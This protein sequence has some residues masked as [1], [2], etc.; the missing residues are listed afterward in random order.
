MPIAS[1]AELMVLAVYMP[2]HD[3]APGQASH[4]TPWTPW[5]SSL[6]PCGSVCAPWVWAAR[7][8]DRHD[9]DV[10]PVVGGTGKDAAAVDEDARDVE[11]G[12]GHEAAGHVLVAAAEGQ[13]AVVVHARGDQLQAVGDD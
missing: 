5:A 10:G 2:P 4:S 9:V 11:P 12:H 7:L 8:E 6:P 13:Q 3:P 1:M